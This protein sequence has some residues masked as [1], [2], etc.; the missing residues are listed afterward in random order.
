[1]KKFRSL[2]SIKLDFSELY[3]D[4]YRSIHNLGQTLKTLASLQSISIDFSK[5]GRKIDP[6]MYNLCQEIQNLP[7][8][9]NLHVCFGQVSLFHSN[10]FNDD[11]E[12][13]TL[14]QALK[15][16]T[17]LKTISL[18]YKTNQ[19]NDKTVRNICRGLQ[20]L[21]SLQ[22]LTLYFPYANSITDNG[23]ISIS[24]VLES[25]PSLNYFSLELIK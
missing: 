25:I 19:V 22:S 12:S 13:Y 15:N 1:L 2:Q 7:S 4:A 16:L 23:I 5:A 21:V 9:Q 20:A 18:G 14:T 6:P 10:A 24:H 11:D 3:L 8:L 17:S